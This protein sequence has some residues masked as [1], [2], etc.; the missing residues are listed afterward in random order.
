MDVL[1]LK[2]YSKISNVLPPIGLGYLSKM[3][4]ENGIDT[5]IF[6]CFKDN[7]DTPH[8]IEYINK[9]NIKIVGVTTCSNDHYWLE[10]FAKELASLPDVSLIVGGPHATGL[11][12]RLMQ[13]IPRINFLVRTEGE[14]TLPQLVSNLLNQTLDEPTL[15]GTNNLV[16]RGADGEVRENQIKFPGDLDALGRPDWEQMSPRE[17][18]KFVPHGGFAKS[19][20]VAQLITSRG[21]PYS[22]RYCAS[23]VMNGKKIRLRSPESI[24][25]EID[26]LVKDHGVNEIHIEDDNFSFYRD[27]VVNL[28]SAIR[29][30]NI[31]LNFGLPNGVRLDKIDDEIL[32]EL[33]SVGFYFFSVG[34]ESGNPA[35]LKRMNKALNLAKVREKIALIK[36][37]GFRVK[38]FF[39]LG[40]PGETKENIMETINYAKSVALDQAFFGVYI[41]LPGTAEFQQLEQEGKI[42]INTCNWQDFYTGKFAE[43][44]YTPEGMTQEKLKQY[45][46]LAYKSFYYR[47]KIIFKM[48]NDITSLSQIKHLLQRGKS[49]IFP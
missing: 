40:Y 11:G 17:Y 1:L 7:I 46:S 43:P 30:N 3:L 15:A 42:D 49:L 12:K 39:M 2:P 13:L 14:Y 34:I 25:N 47:P 48:L 31:K 19:S 27:H 10:K 41:P 9:E 36:Q 21:C 4:K 5:K 37:Y 18:A 33:K 29:K 35:V 22:C 28:C 38:G 20:P 6:H 44:P 26:Y 16:W 24:I 45:V 8:I 32:G 23:Y